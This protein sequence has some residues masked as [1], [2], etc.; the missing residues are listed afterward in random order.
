MSEAGLSAGFGGPTHVGWP[1]GADINQHGFQVGED[2]F[3]GH[4][5]L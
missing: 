4:V 5:E 1:V 3:V 2:V